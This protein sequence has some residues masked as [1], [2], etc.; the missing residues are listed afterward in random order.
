[1]VKTDV[2]GRKC[3]EQTELDTLVVHTVN[4]ECCNLRK[5]YKISYYL[6][7][8]DFQA[9]AISTPPEKYD[10]KIGTQRN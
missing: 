2:E 7:S 8:L 4:Y 3:G 9:Y 10:P 6:I 5:I 1:L